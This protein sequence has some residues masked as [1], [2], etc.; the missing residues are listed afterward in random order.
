VFPKFQTSS[1][2]VEGS[3]RRR[4]YRSGRGRTSTVRVRSLGGFEFDGR[5]RL[6]ACQRQRPRRRGEGRAGRLGRRCMR[7]AVQWG[8]GAARGSAAGGGE[9]RG[10]YKLDSNWAP[11]G[12]RVAIFSWAWL[13]PMKIVVI[14]VGRPTKILW[15]TKITTIFVDQEADENNC[16]IFV[17]RPTKIFRPTKIYVFPVVNQTLLCK[18][19]HT[20]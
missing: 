15:P 17:G 10:T 19:V 12:F 5:G 14:F 3:W 1:N 13:R 20:L 11:G 6:E 18:F 8:A 2:W 7:A 16:R 9:R 4:P